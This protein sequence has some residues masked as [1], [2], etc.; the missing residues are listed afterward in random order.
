[1]WALLTDTDNDD[2]HWKQ[3]VDGAMSGSKGTT[4]GLITYLINGLQYTA[5]ITGG[6]GD[7]VVKM[8]TEEEDLLK[9]LDGILNDE[10]VVKSLS[11]VL[12]LQPGSTAP[13]ASNNAAGIYNNDPAINSYD[14]NRVTTSNTDDIYDTNWLNA[15][16]AELHKNP[17]FATNVAKLFGRRRK[18]N[19]DGTNGDGTNGDGTNG[20][21]DDDDDYDW[22]DDSDEDG[23]NSSRPPTIPADELDT[24]SMGL[25]T[26]PHSNEVPRR[27]LTLKL[28][29][30]IIDNIIKSLQEW[31]NKD[32][33]ATIQEVD[34]AIYNYVCKTMEI[35]ESYVN[36]YYTKL[37]QSIVSTMMSSFSQNTQRGF[38]NTLLFGGGEP[39]NLQTWKF[40]ITKHFEDH[41][42]FEP[43]SLMTQIF[44][45]PSPDIDALYDDC[46]KLDMPLNMDISTMMTDK[47]LKFHEYPEVG[48]V[49]YN[50][51]SKDNPPI[52]KLIY[53]VINFRY[54]RSKDHLGSTYNMIVDNTPLNLM[55]HRVINHKF[56][57]G[58]ESIFGDACAASL[59]HIT[60]VV[61]NN[62]LERFGLMVQFLNDGKADEQAKPQVDKNTDGK[63]QVVDNNTNN[64]SQDIETTT[65]GDKTPNVVGETTSV[66]NS[67]VVDETTD[68]QDNG[69]TANASK[70]NDVK[71]DEVITPKPVENQ[72]GG[73]VASNFCR[74]LFYSSVFELNYVKT[75][76]KNMMMGFLY[77]MHKSVKNK[78]GRFA[79]LFSSEPGAY[80]E[81]KSLAELLLF[82]MFYHEY[83]NHHVLELETLA[84]LTPGVKLLS[85]KDP[86]PEFKEHYKR[87]CKALGQDATED[88]IAQFNRKYDEGL[89]INGR[90][91]IPD[92]GEGEGEGA[93]KN[94]DPNNNADPAD[95]NNNVDGDNNGSDTGDGNNNGS[96]ADDNTNNGSDADDNTNNG[97][98][99]DD[100]TNNGIDTDDD[101]GVD[102][103][104]IKLDL[105]NDNPDKEEEEPEL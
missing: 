81:E 3:H 90:V 44:K 96:D 85:E 26:Q 74:D 93:N 83:L 40:K 54:D 13:S 25:K 46:V 78:H 87:Y 66:A 61:I 77:E 51:S 16:N 8:T 86:K 20:D 95:G 9:A 23:E 57:G 80:N 97:I 17:T 11:D 31:V 27:T 5:P 4:A 89:S 34:K 12:N 52:N 43:S 58:I 35:S 19:G 102:A 64:N 99:T 59:P 7:D 98:D 45:S 101:E 30:I 15:V 14:L 1:M 48:L 71:I 22:D 69:D 63:T 79:P 76:V 6:A 39:N 55:S 53:D 36:A 38:L 65:V 32:R 49:E 37:T 75:H 92:P 94:N 105:D 50:T 104:K 70:D 41:S 72:S 28:V 100:D 60:P 68:V 47:N 67:G 2:L 24:K 84:D 73:S 103:S 21:D 88:G 91:A 10:A 33:E 82:S 62:S 18:K 42:G 56:F 29:S